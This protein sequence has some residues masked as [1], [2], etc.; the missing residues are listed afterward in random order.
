MSTPAIA[1]RPRRNS[2]LPPVTIIPDS[3]QVQWRTVRSVLVLGEMTNRSGTPMDS[4]AGHLR[5]SVSEALRRVRRV[6]IYPNRTSIDRQAERTIRR[7]RI[8]T[9][10]LNG[11][12]QRLETQ[13]NRREVSVSAEV[14]VLVLEDGNIRAMLRGSARGSERPTSD[15]NAQRQRLAQEAVHAAT[16]TAL[17]RL[18]QTIQRASGRR[19]R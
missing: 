7:R 3:R 8:T 9:L 18:D 6:V 1:A 4:I 19:G 12:I 17:R 15:L 2:S 10:Q 13:R 14:S 5:G 11:T 16:Q